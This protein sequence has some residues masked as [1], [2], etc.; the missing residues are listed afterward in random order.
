MKVLLSN[1][2]GYHADGLA[3]LA[4]ATSEFADVIIVAP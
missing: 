3:A 2:D 1:D 4:A